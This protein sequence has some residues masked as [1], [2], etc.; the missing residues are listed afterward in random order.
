MTTAALSTAAFLA[1]PGLLKEN[2]NDIFVPPEVEVSKYNI[3]FLVQGAFLAYVSKNK[4]CVDTVFYIEWICKGRTNE[5]LE[6]YRNKKYNIPFWRK[7]RSLPSV[8]ISLQA[9]T[10]VSHVYISQGLFHE[11]SI[12]GHLGSDPGG[13][14]KPGPHPNFDTNSWKLVGFN[15]DMNYFVK[16]SNSVL[17]DYVCIV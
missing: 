2:L 9:H 15:Q 3:N 1:I 5:R 12:G 10:L 8:C 17:A 6:L 13:T 7:F 16:M 11:T 4:L 14:R